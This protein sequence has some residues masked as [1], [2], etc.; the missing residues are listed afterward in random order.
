MKMNAASIKNQKAEW[1]A[2][3]V[4]LPA[5]D[6]DAMTAKTKEHPV[7]VHFGAGN[8]FRGFIAALQQRL[9]NEG[10][11]DRG[12]IAADTFDYDIIDKIYT[13]FD[14]LTMMVTLNPDGST[15][16]EIIGSVAEGLRADSSDAAMMARFKEIFTDPGLQMIS[17]TITEKGY[18]L[19]RPDGSLMPVVQADIDEGPAHARHAMSMVAALLF[20]RFQAG[21]APL[22]VVSM[23]NCSHNGEKLQSS[24]MTVAKAWAEKGYVGQDFIA[25]LEDE[26]KI[27]FPWSMIDKITPRPHKIVE[28]QLVKDNIEDM[29][30]IVTS[31]NTFIA[32]FVNAERPQYLVVEDKFPNGRPPLEKAGVYMTDR[33]TVNKTERMKVTTCLNPLHTAM[34]VYGCMLGYTLICDE[35]KDA[36][37]VALIKRLGYVEGLPV[38][39]NPGILEPKAFIDEVVEQRLPNPFMPDAPQRIATDTSQKVGIRFGET[40]KSYVAEGRDL[41]TL[42]MEPIV[43][44]KNTFIA[45][46]VNAERPQYL[47]VE[48]KFPNGRPPLEKAGVYMTDRDT[49]NKTERMKVTTCLNPLHTA[50][51]VYGCML[52]Y[53]LICDEMKDADI[54]ALIKRLGYVEGLPVVVNPG[55]LEPKAFID[56]V[57]E[58]RLPNPFMP[59]APQRIATD[60]SQKV[61]IRF[62]ETIKSYVAEG[63]DLNTLVSIPLAIAG[64]LRYLLAVDDNGNAFE[65][66]ADPLKDDL[67]AKLATIKFGAP[68]SCTDQ[69]DS[70]LSNASI[71]GSDL[72]KTVLADKVKAYFKAEIAGPGA[73]RKTLHDAVNA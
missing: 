39:V 58:Q 53:T 10:L 44:S 30:P 52:G 51:S 60:T 65:V 36:D 25:Y 4:K 6:H 27:A 46:F 69:L 19:Y 23:D 71:F 72:T 28:E 35:M 21:A 38:V 37:I 57:V 32:A 18:A 64:W 54:V 50:M 13:P 16:R 41:N 22:A 12:I 20:E 47:V 66:S 42:D 48:D 62:G 59:D 68:D 31:K 15:S 14:N 67:Q 61:G 73:V 5:F 26:S 40:I 24:V 17:F 7:W 43:T 2:L 45:A 8:I 55:I 29:E 70:I 1:E 49:V 63:R 56:E 3:G 34:S 33:D 9:L 11:Q